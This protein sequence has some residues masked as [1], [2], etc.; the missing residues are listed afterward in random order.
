MHLLPAKRQEENCTER[1]SKGLKNQKGN[2]FKKQAT[3]KHKTSLYIQWI[4]RN[5]ISRVESANNIKIKMTCHRVTR[6]E[7]IWE[8]ISFMNAWMLVVSSQ[9]VINQV[10][11][12]SDGVFKRKS[13]MEK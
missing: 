10:L 4:S 7:C 1:Y 9:S 6:D 12:A 8:G 5:L 3:L 13:L 2:I 11:N